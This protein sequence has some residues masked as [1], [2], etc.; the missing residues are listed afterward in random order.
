MNDELVWDTIRFGRIGYKIA[1]GDIYF[2]HDDM[3]TKVNGN[4]EFKH[5]MWSTQFRIVDNH[6]EVSGWSTVQLKKQEKAR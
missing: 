5:P 2:F 3:G 6:L 1:T 4:N